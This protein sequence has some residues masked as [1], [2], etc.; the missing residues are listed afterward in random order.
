MQEE[1]IT[2][3]R[4]AVNVKKNMEKLREN[5]YLQFVKK[6]FAQKKKCKM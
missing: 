2:I 1:K 6:I 4:L 5:A 3:E